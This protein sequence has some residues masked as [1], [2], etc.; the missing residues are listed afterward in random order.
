MSTDAELAKLVRQYLASKVRFDDL[1][2]WVQ[3]QEEHWETLPIDSPTHS[4]AGLIMLMAYEVWEG[5]RY[6]STA[7][8]VIQ[9]EAAALVGV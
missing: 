3:D 4:L 9:Q 8:E 7:R 5:D 6:E 2:A 1:A